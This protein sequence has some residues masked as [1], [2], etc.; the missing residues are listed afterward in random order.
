LDLSELSLQFENSEAALRF[1]RNGETLRC[2]VGLDDV[3][4]FSTDLLV[5]L[6][7]V[8]KGNWADPQSFLLQI[9][10]V[11]GINRY[12]LAFRFAANASSFTATL[13]EHTGLNNETIVGKAIP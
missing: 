2:A 10:R 11:G 12:E 7:F 8:A 4:R 5:G 13:K 6:P 3:E 1:V 9:D